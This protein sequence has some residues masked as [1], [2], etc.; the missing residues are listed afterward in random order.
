MSEVVNGEAARSHRRKLMSGEWPVGCRSCQDF[1]DNGA[2][3]TRTAGLTKY[4]HQSLL[5]NY[6]PA[7]GAIK[8]LR[9]IEL[10]FGNECN[11]TCRHCGPTYSSKWEAMERLHP[12]LLGTGLGRTHEPPSSNTVPGYYKD[13]LDNLLPNLEEIMFSGGEALYQ[14]TH[15]EFID[16]IPSEHAAHINLFYV[17][18][19]TVTKLKNHDAIRSWRKF[20][21]VTVVVS[22][23]GVCDQYEYFRQGAKWKTVEN[24]L[25]I[26]REEGHETNAEITCS[27]YQMFY[28]T[29]TI[30]YLYDNG[31]TDDITSAAVQY[32]TLINARIIPAQIKDEIRAGI[33]GWLD[34]LG[35]PKKDLVKWIADRHI[36]HMYAENSDIYDHGAKTPTWD[37]FSDSVRFLDRLFNTSV[38]RSFPRLAKHLTR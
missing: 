31:L 11:L 22:T 17:T 37:D 14:K 4:D 9:S 6:D 5:R 1:E 21:K 7:T 38:E 16:A 26:F 12:Q 28:L 30:D 32:P 15:Y 2:T 33:E 25:R 24:N 20:R 8:H 35:Q 29:D 10:R 13:I 34:S 18:N 27:A 3:S 23:D 19:G 36:A